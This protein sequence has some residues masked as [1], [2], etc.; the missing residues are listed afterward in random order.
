MSLF[1]PPASSYR[2]ISEAPVRVVPLLS[3]LREPQ[4]GQNLSLAKVG[5]FFLFSH[6][7]FTLSFY[8]GATCYHCHIHI[9]T[10]FNKY[11]KRVNDIEAFGLEKH[12]DTSGFLGKTSRLACQVT[13]TTEMDGMTVFVPPQEAGVLNVA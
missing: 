6:F 4:S 11:V 10:K 13:L 5:S 1:N 12:N 7:L 2:S 8:S 9:P 3:K